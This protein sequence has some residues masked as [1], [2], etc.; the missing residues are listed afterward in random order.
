MTR[1]VVA[2]FTSQYIHTVTQQATNL[3]SLSV[4]EWYLQLIWAWTTYELAR[5]CLSVIAHV[6]WDRHETQQRVK[7]VI[8]MNHKKP[9]FA[10]YERTRNGFQDVTRLNQLSRNDSNSWAT[11]IHTSHL[12]ESNA[13]LQRQVVSRNCNITRN[14]WQ[15]IKFLVTH[16]RNI[17]TASLECDLTGK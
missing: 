8:S 11:L 2:R 10:N 15:T 16:D 17:I 12:D 3:Y 1:F 6:T 4:V 5:T 13:S 7:K 9:Y 14:I